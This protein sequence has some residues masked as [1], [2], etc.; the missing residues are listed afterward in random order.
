[1]NDKFRQ[2]RD[3][4]SADSPLHVY[5]ALWQIEANSEPTISHESSKW[6]HGSKYFNIE[7]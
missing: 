1:M 6:N 7:A 4:L 2:S 5:E 3:L